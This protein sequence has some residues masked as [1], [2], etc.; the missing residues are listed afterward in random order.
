MEDFTNKDRSS[1][2]LA[3]LLVN[4]YAEGMPLL[5]RSIAVRPIT[6]PRIKDMS[7]KGEID[8][9]MFI[10]LP[11]PDGRSMSIGAYL[12][13]IRERILVDPAFEVSEDWQK[14]FKPYLEKWLA[15]KKW[16][17]TPFEAMMSMI[18]VDL[19]G[20]TQA[21]LKFAG[22]IG[23]SLEYFKQTTSE[24][25][26]R[27]PPSGPAQD[28]GTNHQGPA[29]SGPSQ[30]GGGIKDVYFEEIVDKEH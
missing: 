23:N 27:R 11:P 28:S 29:P 3:D 12:A 6:E 9:T 21:V 30:G 2:D 13:E 14:K 15:E 1:G 18:A 26:S 24:Y 4:G 7:L 25:S 8:F 22:E 20:K 16:G 19:V 5:C 17:V 10:T